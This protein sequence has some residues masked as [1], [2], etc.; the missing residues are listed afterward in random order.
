VNGSD[1]AHTRSRDLRTGLLLLTKGLNRL[2]L[3][4]GFMHRDFHSGNVMYD[5]QKEKVYLIDFGYA[6]ISMPKRK[7][8]SIQNITNSDMIFYDVLQNVDMGKPYRQCTNKSHDMAI[9]ITSLLDYGAGQKMGKVLKDIRDEC[10]WQYVNEVRTM[11]Y[12][13]SNKIRLG[14]I[15][16][17]FPFVDGNE[18]RLNFFPETRTDRKASIFDPAYMYEL[19]GITK[20]QFHVERFTM[21]CL[22]EIQIQMMRPTPIFDALVKDNA[23]GMAWDLVKSYRSNKKRNVFQLVGVYVY[24]GEHDSVAINN[25]H[26]L[27]MIPN[28]FKSLKLGNMSPSRFYDKEEIAVMLSELK[29]FID[30]WLINFNVEHISSDTRYGTHECVI[31]LFYKEKGKQTYNTDYAM[32]AN[33]PPR[34]QSAY[35]DSKFQNVVGEWTKARR[36]RFNIKF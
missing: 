28:L 23:F 31:T 32:R 12:A 11:K 27:L 7:G 35:D 22:A 34:V 33:Y 19:D 9:L 20:K 14:S 10:C 3:K 2:Q 26:N 17:L 8:G 36:E 5:P 4:T 15:D 25:E 29:P 18:V 30:R 1:F 6:C 21:Y 16:S 13:I 24:V